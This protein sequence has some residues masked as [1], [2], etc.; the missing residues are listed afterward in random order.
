MTSVETRSP[1]RHTAR[2]GEGLDRRLLVAAAVSG[3]LAVLVYLL[4]VHTTLGQR[5]DN[6]A[7]LG[8]Y[9]QRTSTRLG[10][11]SML[12][13]ITADSLAVVLT[14]LV[15][16]GLIRRRPRL[17][18][19]VAVGAGVTVV[20]THLLR[21]T[22]LHRPFLVHSDALYP[23]NTFPSGHTATAIAC[24]LALVLVSPPAWRGVCVVFGGSYAA[25][26]AAAVQ[27]AGWHR[28]SDA[29]G[30]AFLSFA[31]MTIVAAVIA[32]WRP[33]GE[34]RRSTHAVALGV[35]GIVWLAAATL[36]AVNAAKVLRFLAH[37]SDTLS[38]TPAI[39]N[40]AYQFSVNLTIVV[41]ATLLAALLVLIGSHDLD[42]PRSAS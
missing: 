13:R 1:E 34:G 22:V 25:F 16:L 21:D 14:V 29:I 3:L 15:I 7:L 27:T 8:S 42:E 39:L 12:Q 24:A 38:P 40:D 26:T 30:A 4:A 18:I 10:D 19:G 23:L 41:V 5:F 37:H 11:I 28:P 36:S 17:G 33:I 20:G 31:A 9:Q 32:A 35:L 6:A 2:A